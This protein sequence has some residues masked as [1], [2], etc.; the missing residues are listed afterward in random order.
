M[1]EQTATRL[2]VTRGLYVA[3]SL[4]ILFFSILPLH[5]LPRYWAGPDLL[6]ALTLTWSLRKR[7]A[8]PL[9]I[10]AAVAL[11]ADLMLQRPP[12]LWAAIV[13]IGSEWLKSHARQLRDQ[14]FVTEWL[15]VGTLIL[16]MAL[17]YRV[18]LAISVTQLPPLGLYVMQFVAT[19]V[20]YPMVV[21]V[22]HLAFG[23]RKA[24]PGDLESLGRQRA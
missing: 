16:L 8:V 3:I 4:A 23:I 15:T 18:A 11:L 2:W 19:I 24:Q 10:V 9:L 6:L 17:A 13:V 1:A 14:S 22:S 7:R 5:T 20:V 21:G 12:G